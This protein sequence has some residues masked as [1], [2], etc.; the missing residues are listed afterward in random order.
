MMFLPLNITYVKNP[1]FENTNY[2]Y[3]IYCAREYLDDDILLMHGDLVFDFKVL[4]GVIN[5]NYSCMKVSSTLPIPEKD[6]KAVIFN[7]QIKAV[8]V[9]FFENVMEAQALYKVIKS[10]WKIWLNEIISFCENGLTNCYAE[11]AF[12]NVSDKCKIFAYD[13]NGAMALYPLDVKDLLCT[14][15]DNTDDLSKVKQL[16]KTIY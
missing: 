6:F 3:S 11:K 16:I 8:G 9:E 13:L 10:D 15:I 4:I 5:A 14:E 7:N 1:I 2:I 12:N